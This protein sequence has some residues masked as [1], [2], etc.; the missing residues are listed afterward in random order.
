VR[1]DG[2]IQEAA[3]A[4]VKLLSLPECFSF[5][6]SKEGETLKIAEPL[7]GPIIKRYQSLAR[8]VVVFVFFFFF[9]LKFS[10]NIWGEM[11]LDSSIG[12]RPVQ[13]SSYYRDYPKSTCCGSGWCDSIEVLGQGG[14]IVACA[15]WLPRKGTRQ[16]PPLQHACAS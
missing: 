1:C 6:G 2:W 11:T 12:S 15:W 5:I 8:H 3:E 9:F 13:I 7:T 14:R 10:K 16:P 4:G